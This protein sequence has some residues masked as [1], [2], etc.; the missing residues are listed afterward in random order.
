MAGN[1]SV[2]VR[3]TKAGHSGTRAP[4]PATLYVLPT[5]WFR[6]TW[7]WDEGAP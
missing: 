6:N 1:N 7:S 2:T 3:G 4:E 5:A